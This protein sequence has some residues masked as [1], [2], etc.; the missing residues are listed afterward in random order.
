MLWLPSLRAVR[1]GFAFSVHESGL[2]W[3]AP[4][5]TEPARFPPNLRST[6][7]LTTLGDASS[8]K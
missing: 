3:A 1:V 2:A 5:S 6:V 8:F 7:G 4:V